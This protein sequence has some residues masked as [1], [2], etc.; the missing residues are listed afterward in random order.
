MDGP[1]LKI[2]L[3]YVHKFKTRHSK[4]IFYF[5]KKGLTVRLPDEFGTEDFMQA[6]AS[7]CTM[8][9]IGKDRAGDPGT[10]NR[11]IV[12]YQLSRGFK[13]LK[14]ST[15]SVY[16]NIFAKF[17]EQ[18]GHRNVSQ[19]KSKHVERIIGDMS[20][21]PGAANSFLKR[22][23]TLMKFAY[24]QDWIGR[25]PTLGQTGYES[26]HI[27]AWDEAEIAQFEDHWPIG[28]KSLHRP[29]TI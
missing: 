21:T 17:A 12:E 3:P 2:K 27:P 14:P 26:G 29:K 28:T 22:F 4:T 19:M 24:T 23:K 20:S 25:D 9:A 16:R 5:R 1:R 6:Y 11:L 13:K 8:G 7:A 10:F 15:A 18:H